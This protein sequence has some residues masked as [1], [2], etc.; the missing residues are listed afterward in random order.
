MKINLTDDF[1]YRCDPSKKIR[2]ICIDFPGDLP[3]ISTTED[4]NLFRHLGDGKFSSKN[5]EFDIIPMEKK[6]YPDFPFI[7]QYPHGVEVLITGIGE[8][9]YWFSGYVIHVP[10]NY[11]YLD[12]VGDFDTDWRSDSMKILS[13]TLTKLKGL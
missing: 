5:H 11:K 10:V 12:K 3:I 4:G 2:I 8:K 13:G 7:V 6:P 1:A 9:N